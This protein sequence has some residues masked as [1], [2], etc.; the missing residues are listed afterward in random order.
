MKKLMTIAL[1]AAGV[2]LAGCEKEA[3]TEPAAEA[4][5][6]QEATKSEGEEGAARAAEKA[7]KAEAE[8]EKAE[9]AETVA[10]IGKPAPDFE[11][12]DEA[13]N[14][15]KLSDFKGKV[16]VLE[17]TNPGCPYVERH[18]EAETMQKTWD[19]VGGKDKVVWLA[20]DSTKSV[21]AEESAEWK[22]EAGF[23]H[24]VLQDPAG[25]VGKKYDAKTTPHM[26]VVDAEGTLQYSG[27]IDDNPR[28]KKEEVEN[29]VEQAV[30]NLLEGKAVE[31]QVTKPYGCSVK[32]AS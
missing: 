23:D 31:K 13:G 1:L 17:W 25:D 21:K 8:A 27:A 7:E 16:V 32:Y 28:G 12:K 30:T 11:L 22:K 10:T 18:Y 5:A 29:Y 26:F 14:T 20:V 2:A 4:P 3:Q 19:K 6:T 9:E 24:V 15:H